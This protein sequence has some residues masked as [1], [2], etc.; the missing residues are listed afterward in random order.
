MK[1]S[2]SRLL[3]AKSEKE[4]CECLSSKFLPSSRIESL[5]LRTSTE[6]QHILCALSG[7]R[8]RYIGGANDDYNLPRWW[9]LMLTESSGHGTKG[10]IDALAGG[11]CLVT[12]RQIYIKYDST[13]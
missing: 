12:D 2:L 1:P 8:K 4:G 13:R 9:S 11:N 7:D 6:T 10:L 3:L 5:A